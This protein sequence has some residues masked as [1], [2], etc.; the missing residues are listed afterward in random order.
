M[1]RCSPIVQGSTRAVD[2]E[3]RVPV[4]LPEIQGARAERI[5]RPARHADAALQIAQLRRSSGWRWI[6]SLGGYQSGH[7]CFSRIVG[8]PDQAKPSRP[9]PTP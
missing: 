6:I 5:A 4:A 2:A 9:T 7:S 3:Q 1:T 8:V